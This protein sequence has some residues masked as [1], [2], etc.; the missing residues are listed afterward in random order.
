MS[1]SLL[2]KN[3]P[4]NRYTFS[5]TINQSPRKYHI[6]EEMYFWRSIFWRCIF[7]NKVDFF[8]G[9]AVSGGSVFGLEERGTHG[10]PY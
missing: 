9:E 6:L 4:P 5:R 1:A 7:L 8:S 2:Q 10:A 3:I